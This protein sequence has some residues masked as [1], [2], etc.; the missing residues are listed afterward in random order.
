MGSKRD[1]LRIRINTANAAWAGYYPARHAACLSAAHMGSIAKKER[2]FCLSS[3]TWTGELLFVHF[4][5]TID[6]QPEKPCAQENYRRRFRDNTHPDPPGH[7]YFF[8][9]IV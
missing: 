4:T 3:K 2:H 6:A 5:T 1:F 8:G 9:T 7:E